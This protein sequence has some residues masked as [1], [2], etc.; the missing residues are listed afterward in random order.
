MMLP[1]SHAKGCEVWMKFNVK[2]K[3]KPWDLLCFFCFF[4]CCLVF[5]LKVKQFIILFV[6]FFVLLGFLADYILQSGKPWF[7]FCILASEKENFETIPPLLVAQESFTWCTRRCRTWSSLPRRKAG[8]AKRFIAP[9]LD[10]CGK[11]CRN[12]HMSGQI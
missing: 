6:L 9:A 10:L 11:W 8:A 2:G 7:L 3:S 5:S 4:H 12:F 1:T